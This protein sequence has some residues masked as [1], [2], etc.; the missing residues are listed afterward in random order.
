M[1]ILQIISG[2]DINGVLVYCKQLCQLLREEGHEVSIISVPDS[3]LNPQLEEEGFDI[4]LS[5][6]SRFPSREL[7]RIASRIAN[8]GV[9]V[10]HTHMS[11][12]H[13][14]GA[15][16][17]MFTSVPVVATAHATTFQLHWRMND[18]VIA[19]SNW[20]RD[21]H[22]RYNRV[23][24]EK[25]KTINCFTPLDRFCNV[26]PK[27]VRI[28][29]RQMRLRGD[30][31]VISVVGNVVPRKGLAYLFQ[32]MPELVKAIP[33]LKVVILGRFH[34][35][36]KYTQ[37]LRRMQLRDRIFCHVKWLGIR[38][39]IQDFL[40]ASDL[41]VVPSVK[42][43]LGLVAVEAMAA[44]TPVVASNVGGLPEIVTHEVNGLIVPARNSKALARS[45]IRLAHDRSLR[46][47]MGQRG[48]QSVFESFSP[49]ALTKQ[50]VEVY[51]SLV[52]KKSVAA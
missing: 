49:E 32:A 51:R 35:D 14:F 31:F 13:S 39:N 8:E 2:K 43:P 4:E 1:K 50:V 23:S 48:S 10:V 9:D 15:L 7:K 44:G 42:E 3:W 34:R 45:I 6:L 16:L 19:N 38:E 41:C 22:L 27:S 40:A 33:R 28:V 21:Y 12:A 18:F 26:T 37:Q 46:E 36:E 20:T 52:H 17:K 30:E 47:E 11:R 29:Q 25:I 24:L 5:S